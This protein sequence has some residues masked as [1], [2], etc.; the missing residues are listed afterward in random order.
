MGMRM[1][2]C[3]LIVQAAGEAGMSRLSKVM[4]DTSGWAVNITNTQGGASTT[5]S[6]LSCRERD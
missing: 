1:G 2:H 4:A 6:N 5:T 3:R